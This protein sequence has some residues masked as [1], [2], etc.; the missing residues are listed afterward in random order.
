MVHA[1]AISLALNNS[2]DSYELRID[3]GSSRLDLGLSNEVNEAPQFAQRRIAEAAA[4]VHITKAFN[5]DYRSCVTQA[6]SNP[7]HYQ[8]KMQRYMS[9]S[10]EQRYSYI[11]QAL[12]HARYYHHT[13]DGKWGAKR[14]SVKSVFN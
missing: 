11:Q 3:D 7:A 6:W 13:V 5:I 1:S 12:A 14:T 2:D 10:Q 4:L 9:A 8:E